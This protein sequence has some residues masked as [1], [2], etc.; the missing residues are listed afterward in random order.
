MSG[1][2]VAVVHAVVERWN[3][4]DRTVPT[5]VL[6]PDVEMETPFSSV[7]GTPY[8]GYAGFERW[9]RDLDDQFSEWRNYLDD[10]REVGDT[11][12]AIGHVQARGRASGVALDQSAAW[13]G[14]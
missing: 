12:I 11:V 10:V 7:S 9:M 1:E 5:D 3:A 6:H 4:G 8:R 2:N 14:D 13:V